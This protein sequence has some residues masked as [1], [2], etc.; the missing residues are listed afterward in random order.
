MLEGA[1]SRQL[2]ELDGVD[3]VLNRGRRG[4]L[5]GAVANGAAVFA[6]R[7]CAQE[8]SETRCATTFLRSGW[9][10]GVTILTV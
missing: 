9:L 4:F 2:K 6:G 3:M 1:N 8:V 7:S 5:I 10:T